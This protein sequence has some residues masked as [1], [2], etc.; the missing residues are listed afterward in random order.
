MGRPSTPSGNVHS[1][2]VPTN[3][4]DHDGDAAETLV[5]MHSYLQSNDMA[6]QAQVQFGHHPPIMFRRLSSRDVYHGSPFDSFKKMST[7]PWSR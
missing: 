7:Q 4:E 6:L 2:R 5:N 3:F 1:T